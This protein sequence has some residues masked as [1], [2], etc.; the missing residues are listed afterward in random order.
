MAKAR[1]EDETS[2]VQPTAQ[3]GM[4]LHPPL[5]GRLARS[6]RSLLRRA[7]DGRAVPAHVRALALPAQRDRRPLDATRTDVDGRAGTPQR[8]R[9]LPVAE[10]GT[11]LRAHLRRLAAGLSEVSARCACRPRPRRG[12]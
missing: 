8:P 12:S 9:V 6:E 10:Y 1:A 7:A 2:R 3:A 5:R 4:A 11:V